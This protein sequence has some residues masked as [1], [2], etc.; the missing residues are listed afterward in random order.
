MYGIDEGI[1]NCR[2]VPGQNQ[3]LPENGD[4]GSKSTIGLSK[5]SLSYYDYSIMAANVNMRLPK[6]TIYYLLILSVLIPL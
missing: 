4:H 5:S 2:C 3:E 1:K 6:L